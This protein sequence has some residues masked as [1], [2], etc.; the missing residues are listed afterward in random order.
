[1]R[2]LLALGVVK[3]WL[4]AVT[5]QPVDVYELCLDIFLLRNPLS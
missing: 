1:M 3:F 5:A 4:A 2:F